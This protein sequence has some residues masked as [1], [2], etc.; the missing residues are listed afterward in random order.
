MT[1]AHLVLSDGTIFKG[2]GFGAASES[3][4]TSIGEVVFATSMIGYQ[5]MLTDPSF[6]GQILVPTYPLQ[7]NYG[8]SE[9]DVE[10]K[11]I[12]VAGFAVR[13]HSDTPSHYN[14]ERTLHRY[15]ASQ[16]IA[17]IEGVDTRAITRR[18]RSHGVMMGAVTNAG[19]A[20]AVALLR[21]A[22]SYDTVNFVE[23]V[24][25]AESYAWNTSGS[26]HIA[27]VD[28][29]VKYNILRLLEERGCR[30]TVLPAQATAEQVLALSP[31]GVL[32]SPGPGDPVHNRP[33]VAT[34]SEIIQRI[35]TMGICLGHQIIAR[36]VGAQTYKLKFGHRGGNH[37]VQDLATGRV[38]ITAQN[39]GY[40]V[41]DEGLPESVV[42]THRNLNDGTIEGLRHKD[43]PV[44]T[45]QY[46]SE[47]SPGPEDN[48]YLFDE[49]LAMVGGK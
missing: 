40:A 20:Q 35:P 39:H 18:I 22:P 14:S 47:A 43:L 4:I 2:H 15:L 37:P 46:H 31:D 26:R 48:E 8:I 10:S 41:S 9:E 24:S 12:Q 6:A 23:R 7:G 49:F 45:I 36:A 1:T 29:G 33:T 38:A 25:V 32:F 42:V 5:E 13:E 16:G 27:V 19:P 17:A 30:L 44:M 28:C 21:D 11:Q 34:A 3:D